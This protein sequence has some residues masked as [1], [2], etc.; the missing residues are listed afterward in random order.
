MTFWYLFEWFAKIVSVRHE[1]DLFFK[2]VRD[3]K[4]YS[5]VALGQQ[6]DI[7]MNAEWTLECL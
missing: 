6:V 4:I 2:F 7:E 5:N 3:E 1:S